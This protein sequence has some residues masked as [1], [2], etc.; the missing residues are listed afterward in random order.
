MV[1]PSGERHSSRQR[2]ASG[3]DSPSF[4]LFDRPRPSP[5]GAAPLALCPLARLPPSAAAAPLPTH[6]SSASSEAIAA[7]A[8]ASFARSVRAASHA[9]VAVA[10]SSLTHSRS[11]AA[12][13]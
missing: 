13:A 2:A 1:R 6:A 10:A 7:S 5:C 9:R 4:A 3:C 12:V 8:A 11:T